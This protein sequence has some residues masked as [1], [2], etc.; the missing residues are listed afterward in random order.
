MRN[1]LRAFLRFDP[2]M[3]RCAVMLNF[4]V[5]LTEGA[6][7][8]M[9]LPLLSLAGVLGPENGGRGGLMPLGPFFHRSGWCGA[10]SWR[11]W[12]LLR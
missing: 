6:G 8:L 12:Y 7:L 11:C 9:L 10:L 2:S 1:Y 4:A 5:A 3:L